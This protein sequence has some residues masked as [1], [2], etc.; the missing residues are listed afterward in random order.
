MSWVHKPSRV[1]QMETI[2][3][4]ERVSVLSWLPFLWWIS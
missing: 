4:A 3:A 2:T 1:V